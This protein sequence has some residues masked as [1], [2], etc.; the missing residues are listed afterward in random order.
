MKNRHKEEYAS[1]SEKKST[2]VSNSVP[3]S[4]RQPT[5]AGFLKNP[6]P[7]GLKHPKQKNFDSNVEK[8]L[9][10]DC[11][12]FRLCSS[13]FFK[14]TVNAL[15][16]RIKVKHYT[17]FA[18]KIRQKEKRIK[19]YVKKYLANEATQGLGFT[20][21]MWDSK[22]QDSFCSVTAHFVNE[23]FELIRATPAIKYF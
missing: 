20:T 8:M 22:G 21:D 7:Y 11:L 4:S 17:T 15:D 1:I 9:I 14:K 10:N 23:K 2:P 19:L 3:V 6:E 18:R 12:P 13:E 5:M 16:P